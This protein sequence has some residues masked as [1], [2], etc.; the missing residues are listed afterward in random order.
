MSAVLKPQESNDQ[1]MLWHLCQQ[2]ISFRNRARSAAEPI[3]AGQRRADQSAMVRAAECYFRKLGND[4]ALTEE[5][6]VL[7][8]QARAR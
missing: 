7:Y 5:L 3:L 8:D 1:E 2:A 6:R 4:N